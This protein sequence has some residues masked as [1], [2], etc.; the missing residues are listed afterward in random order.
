MKAT[1]HKSLI[2]DG[3]NVV[4]MQTKHEK[5]ISEIHLLNNKR[6]KHFGLIGLGQPTRLRAL[7]YKEFQ[8]ETL[9]EIMTATAEQLRQNL[10][11]RKS[12]MCK[13]CQEIF[14]TEENPCQ[15]DLR[16]FTYCDMIRRSLLNG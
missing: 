6:F 7:L 1:L 15:A 10:Q 9:V 3:K 14:G 5:L 12:T 8:L 13:S 16:T 2:E 4:Y 11:N